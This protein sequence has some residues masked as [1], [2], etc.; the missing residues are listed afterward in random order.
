MV[1][2]RPRFLTN[3][4]SDDDIDRLFAEDVGREVEKIKTD[5]DPKIFHTFKDVTYLTFKDKQFRE[6]LEK[7]FGKNA[8]DDIF[9]EYDA[10]PEKCS[11]SQK[12]YK[13]T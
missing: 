11:A 6:L 8:I 13:P 10:A 2:W 4:P 9:R 7:H 1:H 12:D 3:A 5:Y